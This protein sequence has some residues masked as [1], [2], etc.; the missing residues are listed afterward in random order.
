MTAGGRHGNS[1]ASSS[2]ANCTSS[3]VK[4]KVLSQLQDI[5]VC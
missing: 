2:Q 5:E 3:T 1:V 4:Y